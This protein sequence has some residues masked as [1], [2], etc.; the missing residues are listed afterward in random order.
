MDNPIE[1]KPQILLTEILDEDALTQFSSSLSRLF[2]LSFAVFDASGQKIVDHFLESPRCRKQTADYDPFLRCVHLQERIKASLNAT[3][4]AQNLSAF[5]SDSFPLS[6][7]D[8][9]FAYKI[10]SIQYQD[11]FLGLI[12]LG[13]FRLLEDAQRE[14]HPNPME[15][16]WKQEG[17]AAFTSTQ[18]QTM[19]VTVQGL[20]S[21]L[22]Q[23]GYARH[24]TAQIHVAAIQ[25]AYDELA[26]KNRKL[27]DSLEK[28]KELDKL[29]TSFLATISHELRTPLTSVIGYSEMLL[30][31]LAGIL[32]TDQHNCVQVIREKGD[33]LLHIISEILD[34]SKI[35]AGQTYL[36]CEFVH[37]DV[38][39]QQVCDAMLP[40]ARRKQITLRCHVE[41]QLPE[42]WADRTKLRQI[43]LNL[44][45][46]AIK[47]T[48]RDGTVELIAQLA[49]H[50]QHSD[51]SEH[52]MLMIQVRDTGIGIP[53][54]L[55]VRIFE[56]FF[57]VDS[58]STR[59]Y[60]GAGLGLSIVKSFV[61]AHG[62]RIWIQQK[63]ESKERS[64]SQSEH[65]IES[66]DTNHLVA[67]QGTIF[68]VELPVYPSQERAQ[69]RQSI[70]SPEPHGC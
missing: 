1:P 59:A 15:V 45:S 48:P 21:V 33:Q 20:L 62:G 53:E 52:P 54:A 22:L 27:A 30:E 16:L 64:D 12:L 2:G 63:R 60:G 43:F 68:W 7:C 65:V 18:I 19:T 13:P 70:R 41:P 8:C 50:P 47:F 4:N 23:S 9:A 36:L 31:G 46:N 10:V 66:T 5:N 26:E 40:H 51:S 11:V 42:I 34:L 39:I 17:G 29:K 28:L 6:V 56:P 14:A 69:S 57:Q 35:E 44:L 61:E 24:L 37:I 55:R 32:T 3:R 49:S 58:S 67:N 25:D 38:M